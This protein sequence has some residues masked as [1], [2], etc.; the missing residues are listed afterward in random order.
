MAKQ[1][2]LEEWLY[3]FD[4]FEKD[5]RRFKIEYPL[6]K[7]TKWSRDL[8]RWFKRKYNSYMKEKNI[9]MLISKT[10]TN[11]KKGK[12]SGRPRKIKIDSTHIN[13]EDLDKI[14]EHYIDMINKSDNEDDKKKL[15]DI[16]KKSTSSSRKWEKLGIFSKSTICRIRNKKSK[17]I[18]D[19][20]DEINRYIKE[21]FIE[22]KFR[23]G[24]E[25]IS[26]HLKNKYNISLSARQVGRR[27][28]K[29]G[30][31]CEIRTR[32]RKRDKEQKNTNIEIENIVARDYDN[33]NHSEIIIA[34]DVT[35]IPAPCDINQNFI[36]LSGLINHETKE[37]ISYNVS[38]SNDVELVI[39]HIENLEFDRKVIIHSD[40]GF[41]YSSNAFREIVKL[42]GWKQSMSRTGNS[43]DNREIEHWFGIM[44]TELIYNLDF[45][46]KEIELKSSKN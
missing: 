7:N 27:M 11:P 31:K 44:K 1:L 21:I 23:I 4:L 40:H 41:Q 39:K 19:I 37:I 5:K 14:L 25:P 3:F 12:G 34:T 30:L 42:K 43:L 16:I 13:K 22:Y 33:K 15:E 24:R 9:E 26:V 6:F 2:K 20:K 36:Y 18:I 29:I 45:N 10:G 17:K 35:Y 38:K 8:Y 28:D 32:K 46:K